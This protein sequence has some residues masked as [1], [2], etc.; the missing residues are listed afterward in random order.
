MN[1]MIANRYALVQLIGEGGMASVYLAIDTILKRE[2]AVKILRGDLSKDNVSLVRFQRE[3]NAATKLS[4][5][6]IVEVYDVGEDHGKYY[7]V[8]EYVKGRTLKD[9]IQQRGALS[10]E[11]AV[12]MMK[13]LVSAVMT[14]HKNGIIHRDIKS[15][16]VLVKDDGTVKLSDFGIALAADAVQLTQT[17][18]IVGSV[19]Y[20][21]PELAKGEMATQQSDI[22]ALGIVF[23]EMLT[24]DVPHHGD[25]PVQVALKHMREEIPSVLDFNPQIPQAVDNIIRKATVKNKSY[26]YPT[27]SAMYDDLVTCLDD[28]RKNEPVYEFPA[29]AEPSAP[30]QEGEKAPRPAAHTAPAKK[31]LKPKS[32][33]KGL[34]IT[35]VVL[36]LSVALMLVY[37]N[38]G[39]DF[40]D[41][42]T[43]VPDVTNLTVSQ[44]TK[45]IEDAGLYANDTINYEITDD[46]EK[47]HVSHTNPGAGAEVEKGS[48]VILY[49]SE[50]NYYVMENFVGQSL[51]TA[52]TA[53][54]ACCR[55]NV[56][57][58]TSVDATKEPGIILE[59]SVAAGEKIN[60]TRLTQIRFTVSAQPTFQIPTVLVGM[61]V[62]QAKELLVSKGAVESQIVLKAVAMPTKEVTSDVQMTDEEGNPVFDEQGNPV[63]E[64]QTVVDESYRNKVQSVSP[65]AGSSYTQTSDSYITLYYYSD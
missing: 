19:H 41:P 9:L 33:T 11:E 21:A 26:R 58:S 6:N 1:E 24:G 53:L 45:L 61:D 4:H 42:M 30:Q 34:V 48:S 37:L 64:T 28:S 20:L 36:G 17:D 14:A 49:V 55:I 60:P 44:A 31:S 52:Q 47:D 27:A 62:E 13:Q 38:G 59:Q 5:P 39:F 54:D 23:Y 56:I 7:I 8:M 50:A 29:D 65:E 15:Q 18:V 40:M 57:V 25:A 46:I 2:V 10:T 12:N 16:N 22:Y 3:A 43:K 32:H 63:Y 51:E 35:A